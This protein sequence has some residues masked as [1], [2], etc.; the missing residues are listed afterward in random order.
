MAVL[1]SAAGAW[2]CVGVVSLTSSPATVQPGAT[3]TVTGREFAQ[4]V[5][6][7]I[8]LDS[9]TGPV[10][11]TVPGPSSTMT[12]KFTATVTVPPDISNG[13]HVLVAT[14]DYHDMNSGSPARSVFS[15]GTAAAPAASSGASRPAALAARSG[16]SAI[17]LVVVALVVA[18]AGLAVAALW[19]VVGARR[20][21]P[22]GATASS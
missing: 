4:S 14:Q 11:T 2:A 16:P 21:S 17:A 20:A 7:V 19:S 22:S 18:A 6:V 12:S 9:P 5:P 10:L 3:L 13:Q 1:A 8:H 15:V